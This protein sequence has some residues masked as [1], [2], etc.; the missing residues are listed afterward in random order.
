M[1][2]NAAEYQLIAPGSLPAVP[3]HCAVGVPGRRSR[4]LL[5][6]VCSM[7]GPLDV[8]PAALDVQPR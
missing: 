5:S 8:Q 6:N 7:S 2:G 1:R 3:D 4:M